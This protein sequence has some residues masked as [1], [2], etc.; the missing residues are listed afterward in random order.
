MKRL[1]THILIADDDLPNI[2]FTSFL[3]EDAGY[4]VMKAY[5]SPGV[6]RLLEHQRP[7]L[8][9]LDVSLP[10]ASGF[11]ICR[12]IRRTYDLPVIF[13][14]ACGTTQDR[15]VG[16]RAGGDDYVVKPFEP[17]EL[18]ARIEAVLRRYY[19]DM[20]PS[21]TLLR[22]GGVAL[23]SVTHTIMFDD[24]NTI[25]LTPREFRVLYYLVANAGRALSASQIHDSVWGGHD[26]SET[27]QVALYIRRLRSK[28]EPNAK[29]FRHI[30][31]IRN[32]G[33]KFEP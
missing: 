31:T 15:V 13:L 14:S 26:T 28:I 12:Q 17:P 33:Y 30:V 5:D 8:V 27:Q 20:T 32:I 10:S 4:K 16:L 7:D 29:R 1:S 19:S 9:L 24:G 2:Q 25:Q 3:L 11:D 23:D 18:L 22:Q 6:L 21:P